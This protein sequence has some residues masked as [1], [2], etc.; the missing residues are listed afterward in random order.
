MEI[1]KYKK[2]KILV[3]S[4]QG[5][6]DLLLITPAL[7]LLR[8][9][10]P[11]SIISVLVLSNAKDIILGNPDIDRVIIYDHKKKSIFAIL[12]FILK[13]RK[14]GFN[15]S[16]CAYPSGLRAIF[17][18]FLTGAPLRIGQNLVCVKKIPFLLTHKIDVIKV[19]HAVDM[20]IDLIKTLGQVSNDKKK[21]LVMPINQTDTEF[22]LR[23]K[24]R[25]DISD[26]NIF[27]CIHPGVSKLGESRRWPLDKFIKLSDR[28]VE[29]YNARIV[30]IG[31]EDD[32][33]AL[34]EINGT[35]NKK[36]LVVVNWPIKRVSALIKSCDLFIGNNSGPMHIAAAVK[37]TTI[38]L[39]GD[40]DPRIHGPYGENNIVVR[41]NLNCSPCFY[42]FLHGTL[43]CARLDRCIGRGRPKCIKSEFECMKSIEVDDVLKE[44]KKIESV[45]KR[46]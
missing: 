5:I 44:V 18:G 10:F 40:T 9:N 2:R 3:I 16:I 7:S 37:T 43:D 13:L 20:N 30:F 31:I 26:T 17:V 25:H 42:P 32:R 8:R 23:Y 15:L 35:M 24:R 11:Q 38:G 33:A 34:N 6:G 39:F 19:K 22:V 46:T 41:K 12:K 29:E 27:I 21:Q 36:Q 14:E 1:F 45:W 4:M 28:L